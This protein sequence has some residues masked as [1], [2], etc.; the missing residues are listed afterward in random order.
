MYFPWPG[1]FELVSCA[2]IYVHLDDVQFSKG[3]FTNRIQVKTANGMKW[4]TIPLAGKGTFT[5]IRRL[6]ADAPFADRHRALLRQALGDAPHL[7]M[8]LDLFDSVAGR[9][10]LAELLAASVQRTSR[11]LALPQPSEWVWAS[12]LG[13]PGRSSGRVLDIVRHLGG[14]RYVTAH[15]AARYLDHA[16]FEAAGVAVEYVGYSR[17]PWPQAHGPFTPYVTVLDLLAHSG[18]DNAQYFHP[19]TIGWRDFV[20]ER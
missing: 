4:M 17:T 13:V 20:A 8:A 14:T 9:M 1:F 18:R 19:T 5:E 15:G 7:D 2:D 3:G 6:A 11:C 12:A 10:P 16:A